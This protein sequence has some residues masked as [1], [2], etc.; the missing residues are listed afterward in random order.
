L[1][2]SLGWKLS[3]IPS[4][5]WRL[6]RNGRHE[7]GIGTRATQRAPNQTKENDGDAA[8]DNMT[9]T[10]PDL[11]IN[12]KEPSALE[13][14]SGQDGHE[15][16]PSN[17]DNNRNPYHPLTYRKKPVIASSGWK[18]LLKIPIEEIKPVAG[19]ISFNEIGWTP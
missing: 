2:A 13:C 7:L 16:S 19:P 15:F 17:Q 6:I 4:L 5:L 3:Y 1:W 11:P 9:S 8:R 18:K 12:G 14:A 10:K